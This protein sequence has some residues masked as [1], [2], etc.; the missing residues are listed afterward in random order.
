MPT[1]SRADAKVVHETTVRFSDD[2]W[3]Q[4]QAASRRDGTSAAAA[5]RGH[6]APLSA[7]LMRRLRNVVEQAGW[8]EKSSCRVARTQLQYEEAEKILDIIY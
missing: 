5:S 6:A 8:R 3:A 4:V 1:T 7:A 2:L